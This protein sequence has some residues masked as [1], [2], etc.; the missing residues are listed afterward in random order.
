MVKKEAVTGNKILNNPARCVGCFR[1][2][3]VCSFRF[4]KAFNPYYA[5][6]K[7]V[8]PDRST[9]PGESEISFTDDCDGCGICVRACPY[10]AL[11]RGERAEA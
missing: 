8:P 11:T 6:I 5:R 9:P 7:I 4:E 1:C 10:G 2:A 3:L